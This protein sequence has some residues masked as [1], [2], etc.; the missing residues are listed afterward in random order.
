[1][2]REATVK[3]SL[4]QDASLSRGTGVPNLQD[5]QTLISAHINTSDMY[6]QLAGLTTTCPPSWA[7]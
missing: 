4:S 3:L 2:W 5:E 1:M 6:N 7:R